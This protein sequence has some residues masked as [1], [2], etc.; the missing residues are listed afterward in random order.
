ML[1]A[2]VDLLTCSQPGA[3]MMAPAVVHGAESTEAAVRN[4]MAKRGTARM[5]A[6][7]HIEQHRCA[8]SRQCMRGSEA[9]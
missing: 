5:A 6:S 7:A 2:P 9:R 8:G 4:H 3:V 1:I